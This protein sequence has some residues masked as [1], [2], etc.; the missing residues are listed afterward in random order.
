MS[1]F[2]VMLVIKTVIYHCKLLDFN[3]ITSLELEHSGLSTDLKMN[4]Y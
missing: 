4:T 1:G 2:F 3:D